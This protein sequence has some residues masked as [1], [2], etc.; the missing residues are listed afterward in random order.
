MLVCLILSL[1]W[2][3]SLFWVCFF[4]TFAFK[5]WDFRLSVC[6]SLLSARFLKHIT[7]FSSEGRFSHVCGFWLLGTSEPRRRSPRTANCQ[8]GFAGTSWSYLLT[9]NWI[10]IFCSCPLFSSSL[11]LLYELTHHWTECYCW[12]VSISS[13]PISGCLAYN[14]NPRTCSIRSFLQNSVQFRFNFSVISGLGCC[15][16]ATDWLDF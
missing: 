7:C 1:I 2:Q 12:W 9:E 13:S 14:W 15:L 10:A 16:F 11:P 5:S 8:L 6:N 4:W 3:T